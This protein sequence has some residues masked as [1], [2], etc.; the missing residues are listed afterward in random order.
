MLY[1][2]KPATIAP[3]ANQLVREFVI[4]AWS[5]LTALAVGGI[6]YLAIACLR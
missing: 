3:P 6:G 2:S 4:A 1:S 5:L